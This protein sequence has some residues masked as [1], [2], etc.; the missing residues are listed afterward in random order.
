MSLA[1]AILPSH[2]TLNGVGEEKIEERRGKENTLEKNAKMLEKINRIITL[3]FRTP[4]FCNI[5]FER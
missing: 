3:G 4:E 5:S 2:H 1:L